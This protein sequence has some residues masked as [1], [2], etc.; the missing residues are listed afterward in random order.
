MRGFA[1]T[2]FYNRVDLLGYGT[3]DDTRT[4][5]KANPHKR[6]RKNSLIKLSSHGIN[7]RIR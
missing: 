1:K 6:Y 3:F 5:G 7:N 2:W 4:H